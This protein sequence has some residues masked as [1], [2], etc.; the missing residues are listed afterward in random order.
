MELTVKDPN[1][2]R[3]STPPGK[4]YLAGFPDKVSA[5]AQLWYMSSLHVK[6]SLVG[7]V[8]LRFCFGVSGTGFHFPECFPNTGLNLTSVSSP[9]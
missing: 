3:I 1:S 2:W 9:F 6:P 5:I 4:M 8:C 7:F